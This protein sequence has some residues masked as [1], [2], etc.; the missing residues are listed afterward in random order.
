MNREEAW[1]HF[2]THYAQEFGRAKIMELEDL[3]RQQ[4]DVFIAEFIESFRQ[5]CNQIKAMQLRNEKGPIGY[6]TYSMLRTAILDRR[7]AYFIEAFGPEWFLDPVECQAGYQPGWALQQLYQLAADLDA[8]RKLYLD[9]INQAQLDSHILREADQYQRYVIRLARYAMEQARLLPEFQAIEKAA[10]FEVRVGEYLDN[11]VL[12]YRE[13]RR[14]KEPEAAKAWFTEH[15][16]LACTYGA[17]VDLNLAQGDYREV[18]LQYAD[19]R[20]SDLSQCQMRFSALTGAKLNRCSLAHSNLSRAW[21]FEADFGESDLHG[22]DLSEAFGAAGIV[23]AEWPMPGFRPVN[24]Q[25]A[26]LEDAVLKEAKLGR[27]VFYGANFN[28]TDFEGADLEK[29]VFAKSD[30]TVLN[31]SEGQRRQIVWQ[32]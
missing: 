23:D 27:A 14:L 10:E 24:F 20:G 1:E 8:K 5:I 9:Q 17:F 18:D 3:Y 2:I 16:D 30:L 31:L 7:P 6:I 22:V 21:I 32:D 19:L 28:N 25:K 12:V 15:K 4:L 26:N 11:S 29:A 13:D